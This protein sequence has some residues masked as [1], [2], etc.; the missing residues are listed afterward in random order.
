MYKAITISYLEILYLFYNHLKIPRTNIEK[1]LSDILMILV[2]SYLCYDNRPELTSE[3]V[4]I[5]TL[6]YYG[7]YNF[8]S[9]EFGYNISN[10]IITD[11]WI[12]LPGFKSYDDSDPIR[13]E[14]VFFINGFTCFVN[15]TEQQYR[16][17]TLDRNGFL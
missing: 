10:K 3:N 7:L 4:L 11:T 17:F 5:R 13:L 8:E 9:S 6:E 2:K 1:G 14:N 12:Y 16:K 15:L